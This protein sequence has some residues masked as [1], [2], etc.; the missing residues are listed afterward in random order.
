MSREHNNANVLCMGERVIGIGV[1]EDIVRIWLDIEFSGG[2][3][4]GRIEQFSQC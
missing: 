4:L 2:R 1:A 3:H